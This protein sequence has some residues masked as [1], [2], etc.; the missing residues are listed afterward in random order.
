[1]STIA[2]SITDSDIQN[3]IY[4]LLS[5]NYKIIM[6]HSKIA[7]DLYIF[8]FE[9]TRTELHQQL[10]E[11]SFSSLFIGSPSLQISNQWLAKVNDFVIDFFT[12]QE[13]LIRT[14]KLLNRK[15]QF[16][17]S[18]ADIWPLVQED[19]CNYGKIVIDLS[20][21]IVSVNQAFAQ[22]H[23]YQVDELKGKPVAFLHSDSQLPLAK[24]VLNQVKADGG[25]FFQRIGH[26]RRD[27]GEFQ[28]LMSGGLVADKTTGNQYI[29]KTGIDVSDL[30]LNKT[31]G[32]LILLQN[33]IQGLN[34]SIDV[35]TF[36]SFLLKEICNSTGWSYAEA[37]AIDPVTERLV[38]YPSWYCG[39]N[40]AS[41]QDF[42][43][44][45]LRYRFKKGEGMIGK[46]W[47]TGQPQWIANLSGHILFK[48]SALVEKLGY[49]S[50]VAIPITSGEETPM[51]LSFL[52]K[53]NQDANQE[54]VNLISM[55]ASPL[56][57]LLSLQQAKLELK[58]MNDSLQKQVAKRTAKLLEL[59][60]ELESFSYS[61]SHDL[62]APLRA[63]D[64]FSAILAQ[65]AQL[66]LSDKG[67][68]Y[69][70]I[71][72]DSTRQMSQLI[73]DLLSFAH[74]SRRDMTRTPLPTNEMIESIIEN[75]KSQHLDRQIEI[76]VHDLPIIY[77][78]SPM[79]KQVFVNLLSNAFKYTAKQGIA[80]I[81]VGLQ[82][83]EHETIFYVKDNGIGFDM[84]YAGKLFGVFQ[85]LHGPQE[86]E[87]TGVGL[88]MVKRI[89][90]RHSGRVWADSQLNVGSTFYIAL[91][92]RKNL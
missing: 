48:R 80:N 88:S 61:V 21:N 70:Q 92:K 63:I 38:S 90:T 4:N 2:L 24:N 46:A 29:V 10:F 54:L 50:A 6:P 86:Y 62:R 7:S 3:R 43:N 12:D 22:L 74:M 79:M 1:M 32:Q 60:Q 28:M 68:R 58:E 5:P 65:E 75:L 26:R 42:R 66:N 45:S 40:E 25:F 64:G 51:V 69:L 35:S 33:V 55:V 89:I 84:K 52:L 31:E 11:N 37:W 78:D 72:R 15:Q 30:S 20:E 49:Q 47:Q 41:V 91:P 81:E 83:D 87:G 18:I 16:N 85:R 59:N 71:I 73:E 27:G 17:Y 57:I 36:I 53:S 19:S 14:Q 9:S 82:E 44:Q 76:K 34:Q 56:R 23:G 77:G 39:Q 8:D 13:L 67:K